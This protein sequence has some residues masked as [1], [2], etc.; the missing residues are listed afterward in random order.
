MG[1]GRIFDDYFVWR[2]LM[3]NITAKIGETVILCQ[4]GLAKHS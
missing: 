4:F 1:S 2:K 3:T